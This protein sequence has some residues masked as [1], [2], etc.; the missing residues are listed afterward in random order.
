M[1]NNLIFI[2]ETAA[3]DLALTIVTPF[4]L[5]MNDGN[6]LAIDILVKNYGTKNGMLIVSDYNSINNY[7]DEI[8]NSGYGYSAMSAPEDNEY[9]KNRIIEVLRDWGWTGE[10]LEKPVWL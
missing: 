6:R 3:K 5:I 4:Y 9:D 8:I 1:K 7:Q 2:W 10:T